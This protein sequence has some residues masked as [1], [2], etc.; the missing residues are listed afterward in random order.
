ME[1]VYTIKE[2]GIPDGKII[3]TFGLDRLD[4]VITEVC[5]HR[6]IILKGAETGEVL[7][8]EDGSYLETIGGSFSTMNSCDLD[9]SQGA[10]MN[11]ISLKNVVIP[12]SVTELGVGAFEGCT[13]LQSVTFTAPSAIKYIRGEKC[14]H[15]GSS[16]RG[17]AFRG[18]TS[19][20]NILLGT[21][22]PPSI[23]QYTFDGVTTSKITLKVPYGSIDTY[24]A[25]SYWKNMTIKEYY[26]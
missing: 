20:V 6:D 8:F 23:S 13:N 4:D 7:T 22:T 5:E 3:G 12:S 1:V 21:E 2:Y 10:F 25:A 9:T 15:V 17:G 18:C 26:E 14:S 11:C 19:L 16:G 24:K